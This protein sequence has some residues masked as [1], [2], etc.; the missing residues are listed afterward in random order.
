MS[1]LVPLMAISSTL[2]GR[3][4]RRSLG[5]AEFQMPMVRY[6]QKGQLI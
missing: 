2:V 3:I 4:W 1:G 6:A 5:L